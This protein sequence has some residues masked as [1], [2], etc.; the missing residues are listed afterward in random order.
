MIACVKIDTQETERKEGRKNVNWIQL[1]N[2]KKETW[3]AL[4]KKVIDL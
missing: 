1:A 2:K 4:M 3:I